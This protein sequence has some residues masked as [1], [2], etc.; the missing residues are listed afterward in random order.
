MNRF[1]I[2]H[3]F[4]TGL[5]VSA[6]S[7]PALAKETPKT[8]D[9]IATVNGTDI[10]L[11][12]VQLYMSSKAATG[13]PADPGS[14]LNEVIN[15]E[16]IRQAAIKDG[17]DK[18]KDFKKAMEVQKTNLLVNA[19]LSKHLEKADLSDEALKKEYDK[20]IK[21]ADQKEYKARHIL[22]KTE[23]EAKAVV[24]SLNDGAD[25]I[26]LAKEKSIGP[27][28][29]NG[30]DLG[31]FQAGTMVPAFADAVKKLDKGKITET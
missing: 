5:L 14:I 6:I 27:S 10:T 8:D 19:E 23:D 13:A 20:Q 22:V 1:T 29:P 4:V 2:K 18:S 12:D 26:K 7:L 28:G 24:K 15:R 9:V 31:W 17:L 16:L 11:G 30:G 21:G 25:F 3:L